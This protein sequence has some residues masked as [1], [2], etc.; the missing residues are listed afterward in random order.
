MV[1]GGHPCGLAP[2]RATGSNDAEGREPPFLHALP[3]EKLQ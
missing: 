1:T 3:R 2:A